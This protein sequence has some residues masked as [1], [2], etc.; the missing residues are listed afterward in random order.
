MNTFLRVLEAIAAASSF[1]VLVS[2]AL[3][4]PP[5]LPGEA[6]PPPV[7]AYTIA[8]QQRGETLA[9]VACTNCPR[10]TPKTL[11]GPKP[12]LAAAQPA[13]KAVTEPS[14]SL[15]AVRS[16]VFA[17]VFDLNSAR[18]TSK[19]RAQLDALGALAQ[20]SRRIRIY[21]YTDDLGGQALNAKLSDSRALAAMLHLRDGLV[22]PGPE[23]TASGRPQCCYITDNRNE[24]HR[25][26]NRRVEI[27]FDLPATA[28]VARMVQAARAQA[29]GAAPFQRNAQRYIQRDLQR[30]ESVAASSQTAAATK[31]GGNRD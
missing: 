30:N 3:P 7:H 17:L 27:A 28:I 29:V 12:T 16:E 5:A 22:A 18:L 8:P 23:V 11:P 1:G 9:F 19:A 25:A 10:P 24:D 13:L 26:P 31:A 15:P 14:L 2:C 20:Q 21:G 6:A 4:A